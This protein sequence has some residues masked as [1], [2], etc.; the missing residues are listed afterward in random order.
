MARLIKLRGEERADYFHVLCNDCHK[1]V[2]IT[3]R[4]GAG[5]PVMKATCPE[6]KGETE[7]KLMPAF[8]SGSL[9]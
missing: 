2:A 8:W 5:V 9:S 7:Q 4:L 6:C 1:H 3:L